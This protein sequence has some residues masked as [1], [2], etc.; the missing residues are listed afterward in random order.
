MFLVLFRAGLRLGEALTLQWDDLDFERRELR[1]RRTWG[2]RKTKT[3]KPPKGNAER[4]VDVSQQLAETLTKHRDRQQVDAVLKGQ[5]MG[6]WV[7]PGSDGRPCY[8][9]PFWL[10]W[11][12]VLKAAGVRTRPDTRS[13]LV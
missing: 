9:N 4:R 11:V 10:T 1:G 5:E 7:F 12:R 8:P 3:I 2:S 13:P 6:P